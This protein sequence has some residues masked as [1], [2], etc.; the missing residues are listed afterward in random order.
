MKIEDMI[1]ASL[2]LNRETVRRVLGRPIE[3]GPIP[4]PVSIPQ[5]S[6]RRRTR[7]PALS[8]LSKQEYNRQYH[9]TVTRVRRMEGKQGVRLGQ[10]VKELAQEAG[11]TPSAIWMR[12][13]RGRMP[14][15]EVERINKRVVLIRQ[16]PAEPSTKR[17]ANLFDLHA[18][19]A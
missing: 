14:W 4:P 18:H 13:Q 11:V 7:R 1:L 19:Q 17:A 12:L 9:L 2:R 15:P 16:R 5:P 3:A 6:P 8:G 10:F